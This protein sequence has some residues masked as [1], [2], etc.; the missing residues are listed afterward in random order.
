ML[1]LNFKNV[2]SFP[3]LFPRFAFDTPVS[4]HLL[5]GVPEIG[6]TQ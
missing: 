4:D 1:G 3:R 6:G 5:H 2:V